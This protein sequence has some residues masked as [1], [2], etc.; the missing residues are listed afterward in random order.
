MD[1]K[2]W[3]LDTMKLAYVEHVGPYQEVEVAWMKLASWAGEHGLF[4]ERTKSYGIY[5]DDPM[6]TPAEQLRSEACITIDKEVPTVGDVKI[7][8][9]KSGRYAVTTHLGPYDKLSESWAELAK[10]LQES[11][12]ECA[13]GPGFEQYLNDPHATNPE[14]L[15]TLLLLP[16]K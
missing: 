2:I 11:N 8:E 10:W 12:E 9:V 1:V 15:V 14:H 4:T 3:T 5:Y 7:K 16:I 6:K 13:G